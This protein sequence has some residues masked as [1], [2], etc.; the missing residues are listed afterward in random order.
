MLPKVLLIKAI[1][2][3]SV[4]IIFLFLSCKRNKNT[5]GNSNT[6]LVPVDI[7]LQVNTPDFFPLNAVG[8]WVFKPYAGKKGVIIYCTSTNNFKAYESSCPFDGETQ[9]NARVKPQSNLNLKDS[10]CGSAFSWLDGSLLN[11][12]STFPLITYN[13]SFDGNTL[14]VYN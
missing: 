10:I 9:T 3:V 2:L 11:G 5:T 6:P 7:Y 14:H 13:T 1:S 4:F 8:G 12:P